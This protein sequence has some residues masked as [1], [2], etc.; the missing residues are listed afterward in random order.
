[1][2]LQGIILPKVSTVAQIRAAEDILAHFESER[3]SC[4][5]GLL[6]EVNEF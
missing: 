5:P 6:H 4:R 1:V 3:G 2:G